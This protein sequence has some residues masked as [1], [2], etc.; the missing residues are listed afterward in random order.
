MNEISLD[1]SSKDLTD[2]PDVENI[3]EEHE[4]NLEQARERIKTL[5]EDVGIK[6]ELLKNL[7]TELDTTK[8]KASLAMVTVE[9]L[10][11]DN[12][13]NKMRVKKLKLVAKKQMHEINQLNVGADPEMAYKLKEAKKEV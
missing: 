13:T 8:E 2:V 6:E 1:K 5:E 7:E 9:T 10:K 12:E 4:I 3:E 11:L